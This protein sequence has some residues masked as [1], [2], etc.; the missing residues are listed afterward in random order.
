M[1]E[2]RYEWLSEAELVTSCSDF[3]KI[4]G[5]D[6]IEKDRLFEGS[7]S[8]FVSPLVGTKK[9]EEGES[10]SLVTYV[11]PRIE[12]YEIALQSSIESALFDILDNY[13][14]MTLV[15]L[16]DSKSYWSLVKNPE[17][18]IAFENMMGEGLYLLLLNGRSGYA[19]FDDF[20]KL[21]APIAI[22]D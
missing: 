6:N 16:T 14:G 10:E 1:N 7:H 2:G 19:L 4:R 9:L 20:G 22:L 17:L 21:T 18:N 15:L 13:S 3:F 11:R 8:S 5:Y 12:K